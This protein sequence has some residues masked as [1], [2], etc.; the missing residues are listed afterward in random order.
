MSVQ[1]TI[2]H[3]VGTVARVYRLSEIQVRSR[4]ASGPAVEPQEIACYLAGRVTSA[5]IADI[6]R[7]LGGRGDSEV[8]SLFGQI[9]LR[10]KERPEFRELLDYLAERIR[11][12]AWVFHELGGNSPQ[13]VDATAL[14]VEVCT[15]RLRI[16]DLSALEILSIAADLASRSR[17]AMPQK[18]AN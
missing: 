15:G 4:H 11:H 13:D 17:D 1:P 9:C 12:E 7:A 10:Q 16:T 2:S 8:R 18:G 6:G 14:A 5:S 3:V